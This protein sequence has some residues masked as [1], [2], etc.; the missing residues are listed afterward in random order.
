MTKGKARKSTQAN[1]LIPH[2]NKRSSCGLKSPNSYFFFIRSE[3]Q[4]NTSEKK[5]T[6]PEKVQE[7]LPM[8]M[9][10][11]PEATHQQIT[12]NSAKL[13]IGNL[14]RQ[15]QNAGTKCH[16]FKAQTWKL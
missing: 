10:T 3:N 2:T 16:F 5:H 1:K 9:L 13:I 6:A 11:V 15:Y 14:F 7:K 12:N 8:D 4:V